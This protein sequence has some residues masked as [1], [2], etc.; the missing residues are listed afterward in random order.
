MKKLLLLITLFFSTSILFAQNFD[1]PQ[2]YNSACDDDNDGFASFFLDEISFEILANLNSQSYVITHHETQTEAQTGTNALT[3]PYF[4]INPITQTIFARILTIASGQITIMPYNLNVNPIPLSP[5]QTITACS[6]T[7]QCW[8][9]TTNQSS[10]AQGNSGLVF[11]YF[12]T[13]ENANTNINAITTPTCFVSLVATPTQSPVYYRVQDSVTGCFSIGII[14]LVTIDCGGSVCSPPTSL[15]VTD[16]T[17]T[18]ANFSWNQTTQSSSIYIVPAG[19]PAPTSTTSGTSASSSYEITGL[20]CGTQ[21]DLYIRN[22]CSFANASAWVQTTFSTLACVPQAG[23]PVDLRQ[24]VNDNGLACFDFVPNTIFITNTLNPSE[25]TLTYHNSQSDAQ[26]DVNPLNPL[27]LYCITTSQAVFAR[28]ENNA[29]QTFQI[30][31]FSLI[32][33]TVSSVVTPLNNMEQCDVDNNGLITFDFTTNAAQI[34]TTNTLTYYSSLANAQNEVNPVAVPSSFVQSVQP[35]P[36]VFFIRETVP[37][38]CDTIYS[39]QVRAYA[40][41]NIASTCSGANSLCNSLGVPFQNTVNAGSTGQAGCLGSTPNQTWFYLPVSSAGTINLQI[42]QTLGLNGQFTDVDYVVYGPFTSL[43][44]A[45]SQATPNTVVSC[46]FSAASIE[47]PVIPNAQPGQYYLMMVTNF[48]NQPGFITI[49][50]LGTSTGAIDCSGLRLNAF[51]DTNNNSIKDTGEQNFTLGQFEYELNNDAVVHNVISSTGVY[52]IYDTNA[53]NSYDLSYSIDPSYLSYYGISIASYDN[54]NVVIG[55]GVQTYNFPITVAQPYTDLAVNIVPDNAPR[56]GFSY[57][58][59]IVYTNNGNQTIAAGTVTFEND[60]D[61]TIIA[62]SQAGVVATAT[63]FTYNFTNLLPFET[64]IITVTMQVPNIPTVA[65]GDLLT[66]TASITPVA[67]DLIVQ[68]NSSSCSQIIIG[69]YD[70]N[71]KM[72]SR[73]ERVLFSSFG[74]DDYLYYTIRFENTGTASAINVRIND[75][76]DNQIDESSLRMISS[77]HS[78][79]LERVDNNLTWR[80]DNI[81][82]PVSVADTEIGKGYVTFQVKLRPGFGVGDIIPNTA[83]IYFDFNPAIITNTFRTEFVQ[84]LGLTDFENGDFIFYPNPVSDAVTIS[85]KEG[86]LISTIAVYDVL[87]KQILVKKPSDALSTQTLDL[88][89]IAKGIYLLEVTSNAAVK[90]VKKLIVE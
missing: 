9:L 55:S 68:N 5:T 52:T 37:N 6:N 40:N 12:M 83:L 25:Y 87:G 46:S 23:Q 71:D 66:N 42:S 16:I 82:L 48:S 50:S 29:T 43:T 41:C 59:K 1:Q 22:E 74:A 21:Y 39:F 32:V 63:G 47:F 30:F 85:V 61:V 65:L 70:P 73:G 77:S 27:T 80:F 57:Q 79:V 75:V 84:Q 13:S 8:D 31:G 4:N 58:N 38:D 81:F 24:C 11:S 67:S 44:T 89:A 15:S 36:I 54:V 56:P 35:N 53:A 88:S 19:F 20:S 10:I 86:S 34:N 76:L 7:F 60:A 51:L 14:E 64:R 28:L 3:S 17:L 72:E 18:A 90:V 62:N 78:Y 49:T 45:C 33:D 69:S 26:N 2:Q